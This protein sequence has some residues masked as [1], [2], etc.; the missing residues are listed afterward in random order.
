MASLPEHFRYCDEQTHRFQLLQL[1]DEN[2][3]KMTTNTAESRVITKLDISKE[4]EERLQKLFERLDV[5]KDGK[6]SVDDLDKSLHQ[7]GVPQVPG[8][9]QVT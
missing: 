2:A 1:F 6:I 5:D 8:Q 3:S 4:E 9:A 7:L